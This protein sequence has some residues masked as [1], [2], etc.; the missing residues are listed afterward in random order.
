MS[1][2]CTEVSSPTNPF[3]PSPKIRILRGEKY[4]SGGRFRFVHDAERK[5]DATYRTIYGPAIAHSGVVYANNDW[6]TS[7]AAEKRIFACVWRN[8]SPRIARGG[9]VY[10]PYQPESHV[11]RFVRPTDDTVVGFDRW[12]GE[13]QAEW[14]DGRNDMDERMRAMGEEMCRDGTIPEFWLDDIELHVTDAHEKKQL[15]IDAWDQLKNFLWGP[16]YL[17][18]LWLKSIWVKMKPGEYSKPGKPGRMIGDLGVAASLQGYRVT[19]FIKSYFD[20]HPLHIGAEC[21]IEFVKAPT[22]NRLRD[23]FSK[24]INPEGDFYFV[25]HSD[26]SALSFRHRGRVITLNLDIACCD[27]SHRDAIF[28]ALIRATPPPLRYEVETL[29]MQCRL[30]MRLKSR[31]SGNAEF[32]LVFGKWNEDGSKAA[33][34]SSGSTL[35]TLLNNFANES[36]GRELHREYLESR[37][38]PLPELL[39]KLRAACLRVGYVLE[40]FEEPARKPEE[41]QFLKYSPCWGF[42][43]DEKEESWLPLFNFGPYLRGA[44][45]CNGDLL[46]SKKQPWE[47]RANANSAGVL[48]GMFPRVTCP[49]LTTLREKFGPATEVAVKNAMK[50]SY[51]DRKS[52]TE[53]NFVTVSDERFLE[54]YSLDSADVA[55]LQEF[56]HLPV[57]YSCASPFAD[58]ILG[59]DYGLAVKRIRRAT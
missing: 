48:Q 8:F 19:S 31:Y 38:L 37:H 58:K 42:C 20:K 1:V 59:M 29:V 55:D 34:L 57:G 12:L 28:D 15:R 9:G 6:N 21:T 40:G 26:D 54:R 35:T 41:I 33:V 52:L 17:L 18:R 2:N 27:R 25:Y 5:L 45:S 23:V 22:F 4:I 50:E 44:G 53:G 10:E 11:G 49:I 32:N 13:R 39:N 24:L 3:V 14:F 36:N 7:L 30:N 43:N 46:G 16:G 51:W 47:A 56:L